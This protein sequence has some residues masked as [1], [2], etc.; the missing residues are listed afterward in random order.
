MTSLE[1][2]V[3]SYQKFYLFH[4]NK[5]IY[6]CLNRDQHFPPNILYLVNGCYH[7]QICI[8]RLLILVIAKINSVR[9]IAQFFSGEMC[10]LNISSVS[11]LYRSVIPTASIYVSCAAASVTDGLYLYVKQFLFMKIVLQI[12]NSFLVIIIH[13][14]V[15]KWINPVVVVLRTQTIQILVTVF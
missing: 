7:R 5:G 15:I 8:C 3:F 12:V 13:Q 4:T 1:V 6:N 11:V 9:R 2:V 10:A 14:E